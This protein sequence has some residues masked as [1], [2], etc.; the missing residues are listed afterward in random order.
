MKNEPGPDGDL[1]EMSLFNVSRRGFLGSSAT[2]VSAAMVG[3]ASTLVGQPATAE[4]AATMPPPA[5]NASGGMGVR[6][7]YL[8]GPTYLIEIGNFR[9]LTDPG[10]DPQ[11]TER[12]EG[13]GHLLTKI[14]APPIAQGAFRAT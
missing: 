10:F 6:L 7:T 14:M 13:P 2:A 5:P 8:G 12:D 3:V 9:I 11:G 1:P 4:T